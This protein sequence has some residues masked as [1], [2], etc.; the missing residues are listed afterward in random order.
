MFNNAAVTFCA[1]SRLA[2]LLCESASLTW[3]YLWPVLMAVVYFDRMD[4]DWLEM[5]Y[6]EITPL[7]NGTHSP[8][9]P[10]INH[11]PVSVKVCI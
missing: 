7:V 5:E 1:P 9:S 10:A 11:L 6:I 4:D 8:D 3:L 2:H